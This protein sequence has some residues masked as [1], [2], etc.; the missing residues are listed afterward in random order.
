MPACIFNCVLSDDIMFIF[1]GLWSYITP[2][3]VT[4]ADCASEAQSFCSY[5][6]FLVGDRAFL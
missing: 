6:P 1:S 4:I 5:L 2:E 3:L